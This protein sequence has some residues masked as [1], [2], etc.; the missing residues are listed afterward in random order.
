MTTKE[1]DDDR[2]L[3]IRHHHEWQTVNTRTRLQS[4]HDS[5][6]WDVAK[7]RILSVNRCSICDEFHRE[8][9]QECTAEG[10]HAHPICE[11]PYR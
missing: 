3:G 10:C 7:S 5:M 2:T 9:V 6:R 8:S 11:R 1:V 4:A